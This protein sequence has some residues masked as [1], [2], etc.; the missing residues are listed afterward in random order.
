VADFRRERP[1]LDKPFLLF[2]VPFVRRGTALL[3]PL[4]ARSEGVRRRASSSSCIDSAVLPAPG[5]PPSSVTSPGPTSRRANSP[6]PTGYRLAACRSA[7]HRASCRA[8]HA[9]L[10]APHSR[11]FSSLRLLAWL[12][13]PSIYRRTSD[14]DKPLS[15][16]GSASGSRPHEIGPRLVFSLPRS[17]RQ[18]TMG[19]ISTTA[20]VC[21]SVR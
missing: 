7:R 11:P 8:P 12:N 1:P 15:G 14:S 10:V 5:A 18:L 21:F 4:A 13:M 20:R 2:A 3:V 6:A 9:S 19:A 17:S 16:A